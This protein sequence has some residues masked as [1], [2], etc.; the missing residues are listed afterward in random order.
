MA[1]EYY[2]VSPD[3]ARNWRREGCDVRTMM[4][5]EYHTRHRDEGRHDHDGRGDG[6][7]HGKHHG[8]RH[9]D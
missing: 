7:H 1:H 5:R 6:K 3:V 4:T 8:N 9:D 2:G